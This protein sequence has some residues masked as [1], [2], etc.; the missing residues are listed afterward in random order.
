MQ[1]RAKENAT[2]DQ[3]VAPH[4][5]AA[6]ASNVLPPCDPGK[7]PSVLENLRCLWDRKAALARG[8]EQELKDD[9]ARAQEAYIRT[10]ARDAGQMDIARS[11]TAICE[12]QKALNLHRSQWRMEAAPLLRALM[13][14]GIESSGEHS[15]R[16]IL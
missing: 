10:V 6:G 8:R 13:L 5:T 11:E 7:D 9:V 4:D 2:V 1:Q 14:A 15:R 16:G 12:A 3:T